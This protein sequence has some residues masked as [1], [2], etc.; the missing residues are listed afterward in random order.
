M[1]VRSNHMSSI[2]RKG[3]SCW[4]PSS[5][6]TELNSR[7]T[8]TARPKSSNSYGTKILRRRPLLP[9]Q[10]VVCNVM[11]S[12]AGINRRAGTAK[13]VNRQLA[14]YGKATAT[15]TRETATKGGQPVEVVKMNNPRAAREDGR[16]FDGLHLNARGYR[17]FASAVYEVVGPMMVAVEWKVW[18][19]K[20]AAGLTN[21]AGGAAVA[22]I[23]GEGF[24]PKSKANKKA[25]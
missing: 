2:S 15:A 6:E 24:E 12:G 3:C 1:L 21:G 17:A 20:L 14:L 5:P 19:S 7:D 4:Q 11:T 18:K 16:A 10:V 22:P 13:R 23:S 25:D 8:G 9:S